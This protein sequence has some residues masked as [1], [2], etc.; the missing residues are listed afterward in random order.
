MIFTPFAKPY[1]RLSRS[2]LNLPENSHSFPNDSSTLSDD[3]RA[4]SDDSTTLSDDSIAFENYSNETSAWNYVE[5]NICATW[6]SCPYRK[7][8]TYYIEFLG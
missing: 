3:S 2:F 4:S 6:N 7:C 8:T 5:I 1:P